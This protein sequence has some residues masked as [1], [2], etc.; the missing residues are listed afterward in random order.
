MTL[1][2]ILFLI[3]YSRL[4]YVQRKSDRHRIEHIKT[5]LQLEDVDFIEMVNE[6]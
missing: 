5:A 4:D 2:V 1:T 3:F 6:L